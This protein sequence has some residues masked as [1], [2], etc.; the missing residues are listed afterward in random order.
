MTTWEIFQ[1]FLCRAHAYPSNLQKELWTGQER[2]RPQ[3]FS[4]F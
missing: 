3:L 4:D 2:L 1:Q